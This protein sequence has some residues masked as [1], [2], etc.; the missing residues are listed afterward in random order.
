MNPWPLI[1]YWVVGCFFI[2]SAYGLSHKKCPN[3]P[4]EFA[5]EPAKIAAVV[6][7]WPMVM[8]FALNAGD[9]PETKCKTSQEKTNG[10]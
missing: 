7:I 5:T 2:G 8:F 9:P 6:A 10:G 3:D 1:I 4:L